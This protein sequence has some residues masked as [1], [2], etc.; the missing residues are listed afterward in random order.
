MTKD[1]EKAELVTKDFLRAEVNVLKAE[2]QAILNRQLQ[3]MMGPL[4]EPHDAPGRG[5]GLKTPPDRPLRRGRGRC[6]HPRTLP[7]GP[8]TQP[9][10]CGLFLHKENRMNRNYRDVMPL[11]GTG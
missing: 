1:Q 8:T 5:G 11:G 2:I 4:A 9:A 10:S 6:V 7:P 3:I